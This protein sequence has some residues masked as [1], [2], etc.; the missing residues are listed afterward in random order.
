MNRSGML[1]RLS[2]RCRWLLVLILAAS[3][4]MSPVPAAA[5]TTTFYPNAAGTYQAWTIFGGAPTHWQA[6]SDLSDSTGVQITG[7][8]TSRETENLQDTSQT[9]TINSV[10]AYMRARA[11]SLPNQVT[12]VAAGAG[13][14][15]TGNPTPS[16][17][18]GLQTNDLIL[19]QVTVRDTTTTPTT[20]AGFTLLYGPDSTGTGRQW[21]YY[22]FSNGSETGTITV[23]V[24][25][26][27]CKIARMYSFRNVALSS[28]TE[29][30]S[31]GT[32]TGRRIYAQTVATTDVRRLA[33]S[34]VF[35]NYDK[36]VDSFTGE[37]GGDWVEATA[38]YTTTADTRGCAQLQTA[39]MASA[40]TISGGSYRM[41]TPA[42][43][44]GV[45]AFALIPVADPIAE[46]AVI[47]WRTNNTDY[48]SSSQTISRTAFTNYFE[49]R[50]INPST[51][52]AW[53]WAEVNA[54]Q[55][56]S[57]A[58][59]LGA[60]EVI[61]CSEYWIVVD[62]T[63]PIPLPDAN[64][65]AS[66]TSGCAPLNVVFT[67]SST[68]SPTSW[69]WSFPGGN[70]STAS[71]QGPHS[72]IYNNNGT[73]NVS[74]TVTNANGSDTETKTGYITVNQTPTVTISG[75]PNICGAGNSTALTANVTGG[76]SPYSYDWSPSTA[77]GSGAGN[78]FTATGAGTVAV[79]VTDSL[80]C[81]GRAKTI[82][83][84][85]SALTVNISGTLTFC[86]SDNTTLTATASNGTPPYT[87][88]WSASTAPGSYNGN[89]YTATDSGSV[90]VTVT[91]SAICRGVVVSDTNAQITLGNIPNATYPYNAVLGYVHPSW[92][93]GLTGYTFDYSSPGHTNTAAQWIWESYYVVHPVEGDIVYVQRS[94]NIP[95]AP[96]GANI[97]IT[98]DNAYEVYINGNYLGRAQILR[99]D[100]ETSDLTDPYISSSGWQSVETWPVS[101]GMLNNG[102]NTLF[103]K[104]V[105]EQV[106]GGTP[107][108]NPGG[109]I[110][111]VV[112]DYTAQPNICGCTATDSVG[113]TAN[114]APEATTSSNSPV[115]EGQTIELYGG[116]DGMTSYSW[117]GPNGFLSPLQ[118]PVIPN[119]TMAMSGTY[120][121][122]LADSNG[123]HGYD[124]TY[125]EVTGAP[126]VDDIQIYEDSDC[127][128]IAN[129]MTP[130]T[131][132]YVRVGVTVPD[133]NLTN[134]QTVMVTLFYD[135]AGSNPIA[136]T[137]GD[138][139][140]CAILSCTVGTPPTWTIEP[141]NN[142]PNPDDNTTW[143][144]VSSE[145]VQPNLN[146]ASGNWKFA[147]KPGKVA[148][149]SI[150]PANWDAQGK[151]LRTPSQT[152]ERYVRDK[153]M[154]W[155]GE[156]DINPPL[157]VNWGEVPLG[158]T[159]EDNSYNPHSVSIKYIANGNYYED[160]KSS[161]AWTGSGET[162]M[163]DIVGR[164]PPP[165]GMFALMADN[166]AY[167]GD[168]L[169]VTT[170]YKHIN[171][172]GSLTGEDGVTVDANSLW[173]SLGE[174]GIA[175]VTYSGNIYYQIAQ[176]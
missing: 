163:L 136:P 64:F 26:T 121:L 134:L 8:T 70:P 10:T 86:S 31:F 20:P 49:T 13:S 87:Y 141:N 156:I 30:A 162:V 115:A 143:V 11:T 173:L 78:T 38:E 51:G 111:E 142:P 6:T 41:T 168:A 94:F 148:T 123:C 145:C 130:Q 175:P 75:N 45:R 42:Y 22:R 55:V 15:T 17:P 165:A 2:R 72:I 109:L 99:D 135:A 161:D 160:T 96:T 61:Q 118:N 89:T 40:G 5:D 14:G 137:L 81:T 35:V 9:G 103:V 104:A 151:A 154:N 171:A 174:T 95:G 1:V 21:I 69:S 54:L 53:T 126:T 164:N 132:Y 16:Y 108:T 85:S 120:Y 56:G 79:A 24:V 129:S 128:V 110:F 12:Y 23:T 155:Y 74:L 65:T 122:T 113:V 124:S 82:V 98:C 7:N 167:L 112:Y 150:A 59:A 36:A 3:F 152:G 157:L 27:A 149:E 146:A 91:D 107:T 62:Y 102:T 77:P 92:W 32:G 52:S 68:G 71:G 119:A 50:A 138:T 80:G 67:D 19:L 140:T 25:G 39:I 131:I 60:G 101:A 166:T 159:F 114:P 169:V 84:I 66:P 73:Y 57:R 139:Q 93:G 106:T 34:F 153:A 97:Y 37:T 18:A 29:A 105:N 116:P 158:L 176:R 28:F 133:G 46:Q 172:S 63:P 4:L 58:S 44:W 117:S 170:E 100:W 147:F 47:V 88:D 83:A 76:I 33:V 144:I 43:P 90:T 125:V 48:E 127:T